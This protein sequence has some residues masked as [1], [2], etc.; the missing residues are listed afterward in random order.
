MTELVTKLD[1]NRNLE[2]LRFKSVGIAYK[3]RLGDAFVTTLHST[4]FGYFLS[5]T[6]RLKI[7]NMRLI[8]AL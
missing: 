6:E 4:K 7:V 2:N 8:L 3:D 5:K 1:T